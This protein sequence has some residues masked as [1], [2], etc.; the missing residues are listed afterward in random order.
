MDE[1]KQKAILAKK[2]FQT[3]L[4]KIGKKNAKI[5][6]I[7]LVL[8]VTFLLGNSY[9]MHRQKNST[10]NKLS[11]ANGS[12]LLSA[13]RWTSVGK[14]TEVS[15]SKIKIKDSRDQEKEA[16]I[17]KDTKIVN[18]KGDTVTAGDLKKD[19]SVIISGEKDGDKLKATRIRL[20]Q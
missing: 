3:K 15:D 16:E 10:K 1:S 9:G 5:L 6:G 7:V 17:N 12:A 8:A 4:P 19:Q 14:I 18:R 2:K 13:N 11:S 20:Q